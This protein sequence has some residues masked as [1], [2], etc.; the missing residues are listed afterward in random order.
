M[1]GT[2]TKSGK[3]TSGG[4]ER[5]GNEFGLSGIYVPFSKRPPRRSLPVFKPGAFEKGSDQGTGETT[6]NDWPRTVPHA[7]AGTDPETESASQG[8]GQ[9]LL[10]RLSKTRTKTNKWVCARAVDAT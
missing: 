10:N 4:F 8:M 5:A 9:L 1:D 6:A 2:G 7:I 3:D